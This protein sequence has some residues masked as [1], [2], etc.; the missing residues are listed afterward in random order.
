MEYLAVNKE[1]LIVIGLLLVALVVFFVFLSILYLYNR[2]NNG[3]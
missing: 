2:R 1:G 3:F